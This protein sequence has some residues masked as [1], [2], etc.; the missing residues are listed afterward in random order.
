MALREKAPRYQWPNRNDK[1]QTPKEVSQPEPERTLLHKKRGSLFLKNFEQSQRHLL[2][3][4]AQVTSRLQAHVGNALEYDQ[5]E[6]HFKIQYEVC[7]L[8]VV[9]LGA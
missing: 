2:E 1:K 9:V 4:G 3:A 8:H 6:V 5:Y 7:V